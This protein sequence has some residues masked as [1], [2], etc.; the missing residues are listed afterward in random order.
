MTL[1]RLPVVTERDLGM[2]IQ[3]RRN[4]VAKPTLSELQAAR[5][6]FEAVEP[7]NL[8]YRLSLHLMEQA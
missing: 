6:M 1:S 2:A 5:A 7:R 4:S 3:T 8:F